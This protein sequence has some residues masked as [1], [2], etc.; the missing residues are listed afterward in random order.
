MKNPTFDFRNLD[1]STNLSDGLHFL[2]PLFAIFRTRIK[3]AGW[4][5]DPVAAVWHLPDNPEAWTDV[6][7]L[8]DALDGYGIQR[9][10]KVLDAEDWPS[11]A[12]E[13]R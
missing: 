10:G 5:Y 11:K 12:V 2:L 8:L 13:G 9:L 7:K 1:N 3:D 4:V 6:Q